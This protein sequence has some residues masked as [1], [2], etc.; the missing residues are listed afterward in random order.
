MYLF[1]RLV[2]FK[3]VAPAIRYAIPTAIIFWNAVEIL[4]RWGL[5][6]EIWVHPE[7]YLLE[8]ALIG[9]SFALA[10]VLAALS[11]GRAYTA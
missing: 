11:P 5:F 6:T 7:R 4:G 3:R 8:M 10:F 2:R 9:G 1:T